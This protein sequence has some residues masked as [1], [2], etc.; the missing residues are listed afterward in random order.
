METQQK[1]AFENNRK[2]VGKRIQVIVDGMSEREG[3]PWVGR[4]YGDAPE[5]DNSI[6]F[7]DGSLT[8]G[9]IFDATILAADGYDL[10][11]R[12]AAP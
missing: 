4:T 2:L 3:L 1:I 8:P 5:I 9:D 10:I 7:A 12:R 11:G 6:F